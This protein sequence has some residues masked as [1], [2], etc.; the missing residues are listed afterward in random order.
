MNQ[1]TD[2][3]KHIAPPHLSLDINMKR[4]GLLYGKV[5]VRSLVRTNPS[6]SEELK[7]LDD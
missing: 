4:R 2:I 6:K 1:I 7:Q 5:Y 3:H